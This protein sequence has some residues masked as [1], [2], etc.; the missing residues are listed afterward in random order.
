MLSKILQANDRAKFLHMAAQISGKGGHSGSIA[1]SGTQFKPAFGLSGGFLTKT[2]FRQT[3]VEAIF[4]S[5]DV[6]PP[7]RKEHE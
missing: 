5:F 6:F 1:E 2:N 4:S 3:G 7:I